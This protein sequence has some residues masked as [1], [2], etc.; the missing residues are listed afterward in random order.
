MRKLLKPKDIF[1]FMLSGIGD[2]AEEIRDPAYVVSSA[3][4]NMYGFIPRRYKRSNFL[5]MTR[6][7][8]KTGDIEKVM[9]GDKFYL[10]ITSAGKEKINRDFPIA[11]LIKNWNKRWVIVLFDIAEKEKR[12]RDRFRN[13][14]Q[15][16]GFG[17]LQESVWITPLPIGQDMLEVVG[18]AGLSKSVFVLEVSHLLLGNPKKLTRKVWRL[19][20]LEEEYRDLKKAIKEVIQLVETLRGRGEKRKAR[21]KEDDLRLLRNKQ[22]TLLASVPPLPVELLPE[23]LRK[24]SLARVFGS[25]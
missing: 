3:Y 7:A 1:L 13:K 12:V 21:R 2:M 10:R 18:S 4:E 20:R 5:Q 9:K 14:L 15:S 16:I 23:G 8:L 6:R 22:L 19:D 25:L 24:Q 11:S 17:M